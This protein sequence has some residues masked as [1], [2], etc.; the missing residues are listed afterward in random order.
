MLRWTADATLRVR[1]ALAIAPDGS[2]V[3]LR[4]RL[5]TDRPWQV[6][7]R[8]GPDE[9]GHAVGFD[10]TGTTLY[11]VGNHHAASRRLLA[12]DLVTGAETVLAADPQYDVDDDPW[13][14][15]AGVLC[16]PVTRT[17]QAVAFYRDRLAWH[18]LDDGVAADFTAIAQRHAGEFRVVSRDRADR[19]WLIAATADDRPTRYHLYDRRAKTSRLLFSAY[20]AL[21]G[22]PLARKRSIAFAA[23][24]GLLI[25]GYLTL[26]SGP[27][28]R[29]LPTVLLVHGGPHTR[30]TW[31]FD[32]EVQWLANR[33]YAVLQVNYRGSTGYGQAFRTAGNREWG[34]K[35]HD[36]LIA[37]VAWLVAQGIAD[38]RRI[39]S[40]GFSFGG[41]ATLAGLA[42]APDVFA[43]GVCLCGMS[44]LVAFLRDIP[45]YWA[46]QRAAARRQIGD[47]TTEEAFLRSRSPLFAADR[48]VAPLLIAHGANDPRIKQVESDRL[49][50][51]L[52]GARK[53]V[54]YI[55]YTDEGHGLARPANRL[56]FYGRVEAFLAEHLGGRLGT[57]GGDP[58][59]CRCRPVESAPPQRARGTALLPVSRSRWGKKTVA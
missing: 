10:G 56:H 55:V 25:H 37:G 8:W 46:A 48:I 7:R 6:A 23:R 18:V 20:P 30:D 4:I 59:P 29:G 33:G 21:D 12:L 34:G 50:A 40:M 47:V 43:A 24:D 32:P 49:V 22:W 58:R 51:A 17:V 16:D 28:P 35:M 27:E 36:D 39:A 14:F 11:V 26:P 44:D 19:H 5:A 3:A 2:G 57:P 38:R 31:A 41:Y 9:Q 13:Y 53:T 42:F 54:E 1:A 45:P 15:R 52:R